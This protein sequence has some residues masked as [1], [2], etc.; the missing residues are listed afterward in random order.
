MAISSMKTGLISRKLLVG[1]PF[2]VPT[3]FESIATAVG[4]GSSGL[5][6]FS[7][8]PSTYKHL[9]IRILCKSTST[10]SPATQMLMTFNNDSGG[11]YT[12]HRLQGNGA[13]LS[14]FGTTGI[15]GVIIDGVVVRSPGYIDNNICG[16]AIIDIHNYASTTQNKTVKAFS[17]ADRNSTA[18]DLRIALNSS[19][20]LNTSAISTITLDV[21]G[22]NYATNSKIALYGIK[23]S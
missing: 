12:Y 23:G 5:I 19:V 22:G 4:T 16:T 21:N 13:S 20:W 6:T 2:F 15:T 11:N 14:A 3:N 9:Q 17:G 10:G 18:E 7:S 8:I 1:N